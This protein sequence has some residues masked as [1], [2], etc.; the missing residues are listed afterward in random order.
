MQISLEFIGLADTSSSE[1]AETARSLS[2]FSSSLCL[3]INC[4]SARGLYPHRDKVLTHHVSTAHFFLPSARVVLAMVVV[5]ERVVMGD[6]APQGQVSPRWQFRMPPCDLRGRVMMLIP[7]GFCR[8]PIFFNSS[9]LNFSPI[10]PH[11]FDV[12]PSW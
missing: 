3:L 5:V 10:H 6:V 8:S 9:R 12:W 7:G 1:I 4:G 11:S 2:W